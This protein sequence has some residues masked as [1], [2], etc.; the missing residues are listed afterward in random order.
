[1]LYC[2]V[3]CYVVL[4]C[5]VPCL[6]MLCLAVSCYAVLYQVIIFPPFSCYSGVPG[7]RESVFKVDAT[8]RSLMSGRLESFFGK[9]S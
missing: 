7:K 1:M 9:C 3:L 5:A 2:F 8:A 4:V 6:D